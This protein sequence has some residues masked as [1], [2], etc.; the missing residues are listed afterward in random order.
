MCGFQVKEVLRTNNMVDLSFAQAL[1][2]D[3]GIEHD[4]FDQHTSVLE[5]SVI[6]IERRVLVMDRDAER[7]RQLIADAGLDGHRT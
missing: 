6:A 1:L 7:A 3:A 2:R 4:V 5:G